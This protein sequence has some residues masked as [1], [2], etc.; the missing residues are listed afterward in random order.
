MN[1]WVGF[2]WDEVK[3]LVNQIKHGVSFE[4]AQYAFDDPK[5]IIVHDEAHGK[6][7][8]RFFCFGKVGNGVLT[9]RYTVRGKGI[10]IIG[11]GYWRQG[12]KHYEKENQI[13]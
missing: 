5:R 8:E 7:E 12:R 3:N 1:E 4:L 13:H 9:V 10:R 6:K 11:A 2:E